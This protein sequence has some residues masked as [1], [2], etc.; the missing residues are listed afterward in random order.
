MTKVHK[1][2]NG[3]HAIWCPG[4]ESVH[5]IDKRWAFNGDLDK[6]TFHPSLKVNG[7]PKYKHPTAPLCH[8]YIVDG[9]IKFLPDCTH[10][11]AGQTVDLPEFKWSND[12]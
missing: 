8:S 2:D 9:E 6:P 10:A 11:M 5:V 7:N 4:C 3:N 1:S 12:E